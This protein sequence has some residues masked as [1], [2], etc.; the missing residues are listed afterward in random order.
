MQQVV[1]SSR[2]ILE[3][4]MS[5]AVNYLN[6]QKLLLHQIPEKLYKLQSI[7]IAYSRVKVS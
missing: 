3:E 2:E 1:L 6:K 7:G 4:H 5:L